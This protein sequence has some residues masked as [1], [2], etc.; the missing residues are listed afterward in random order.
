MILNL[1]KRETA[2][3]QVDGRKR[4]SKKERISILIRTKKG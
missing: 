4:E 3:R 1:K 2:R